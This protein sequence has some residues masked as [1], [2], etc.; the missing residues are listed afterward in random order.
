MASETDVVIVG[1]GITGCAAAKAL[2]TDHDVTVLEQGQIAGDASGKASGLVTFSAQRSAL[3]E[4]VHYAL[5]FF[6]DYVGTDAFEF[7]ESNLVEL[8]P[9][10]GEAEAKARAEGAEEAGFPISF[11]DIA[12][13]EERY[14]GVYDLAGYVGAIE[15]RDTGWVDP[16][17]CTMSYKADA[18]S[19]GAE[20]RTDTAVTGLVVEGG[21]VAG[22]ETADGRVE[23]DHV[24]VAAG[25]RT[26]ELLEGVVEVP[27]RPMRYQTVNLAPDREIDADYPMGVDPGTGFYWRPEHNDEIHIGGDEYLVE[28]AGSVRETVE[29]SFRRKV[30]AEVPSFL[31]GFDDAEI[32]G[33]DTCPTG[34]A[35]TPDA[36]PVI[37]TPDE[38]PAGLTVAAG[39]H[40]YG[41]MSSPVAGRAVRAVVTG[42]DAP[43]PLE[44]YRLDRLDDR[45]T[46]FGL[47]SLA[48]KRSQHH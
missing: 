36:L 7:N 3:P 1:G 48:E 18:E 42:E 15:S 32:V 10:E 41:I 24:V 45:S 47:V 8:V 9:P 5:S 16:Y 28:D 35:A 25:W 43:F 33:E 11:L 23:A 26:R 39:F 37:D 2:A 17:T 38:G 20:V 22:V 31:E 29:E 14:P 27:L 30:A 12:E 34:D 6:A 21:A 19:D 44:P 4:A 40:G 13:V 46:D